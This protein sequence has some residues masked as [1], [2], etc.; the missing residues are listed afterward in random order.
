MGSR[1]RLLCIKHGV[2]QMLQKISLIL[3]CGLVVVPTQYLHADK[4]CVYLF[5]GGNEIS[6]VAPWNPGTLTTHNIKQVETGRTF[7]IKR[8]S[9]EVV[10]LNT[11][12]QKTFN[13]LTNNVPVLI[14]K[15]KAIFQEYSPNLPFQSIAKGISDIQ[16][17]FLDA[18]GRSESQLSFAKDG[19]RGLRNKINDEII[20]IRRKIKDFHI[21][22]DYRQFWY[23]FFY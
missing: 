8:S 1:K 11:D 3:L 12:A 9:T 14:A 10:E 21:V 5:A 17:A 22:N 19:A 13:L 7:E 15:S 6:P 16:L 4:M 23:D 18:R 2:L 20:E